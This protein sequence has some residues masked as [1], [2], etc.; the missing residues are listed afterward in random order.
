MTSSNA[1]DL[2][3]L[4]AR[5]EVR[6]IW[7]G[8]TVLVSAQ[9]GRVSGEELQGLYEQNTRILSRW[10]YQINGQRLRFVAASPVDSYSMLAYY[11]APGIKQ[12]IPP[13]SAEEDGLVLRCSRFVGQG[14]HEDIDLENFTQ[15]GVEFELSLV[16]AADFADLTAVS[17]GGRQQRALAAA[18]WSPSV[19]GGW[20]LCLRSAELGLDRAVL[21][22]APAAQPQP[23]WRDGCIAYRIALTPRQRRHLCIRVTPVFD[24][25]A[26]R[27]VYGCGAFRSRAT[28]RDR[29]REGFLSDAPRVRTANAGVQATW[30]RAVA[31]LASLARY[32]GGWPEAMVP[33]AGI[34]AYMALFGRDIL[35]AAYQAGML[36]APLMQA[37]LSVSAGSQAEHWDDFYDA[38]P[39]RII[40]QINRGPLATLGS[41]PY[42]HYY[43]DY[44]SPPAFLIV[45]GQYYSWTGDTE[46]VRRFAGVAQRV[47]NWLDGPADLDGDGFVEY[48]TRSP[49]GQKN[50]GWKDSGV[51]MVDADGRG[52]ENPIASCELQG[53][54][55]AAKQQYALALAFGLHRFGEARRLLREA[56]ELKQRFNRAYWLPKE[57]F[58]ASALGPDKR[59][60]STIGSNA[61]HALA[62]G[63]IDERYVP[64]V[65]KRLFAPDMFSGWGIRTLSS[66]HPAYNP[67]SYQ[68]GSVWPMESATIAFGLKRYGF[69][70]EVLA[71]AH[72]TFDLAGLVSHRQLPEVVGGFPRDELHPHPGLYPQAEQPQAWSAAAIP[73]FVQTLL[74]LFPFAP[75]R[76][77]LIDPVLPEWLPD[78]TL[79][80]LRIGG[81]RVSLRF[82]RER[83]GT[84]GWKLLSKQGSLRVIQ[85]PPGDALQASVWQRGAELL[86]SFIPW[87]H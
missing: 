73:Q 42:R 22:E 8:Q 48:V 39:G 38:Q 33:S 69:H 32:E 52:I 10:E 59:P 25:K 78:L 9:D 83:D 54:T 67:L 13:L 45:L 6:S 71:L 76:L 65:A 62:T 49:Q 31:D 56:A 79:S 72:A 1:S 82:H 5:P 29:I 51:A 70:R 37:A 66:G 12:Q 24:G 18:A 81:A 47:L 50:Q 4:R 64:A 36:S 57:G 63:I 53:Y 30:E 80:G 16:L 19:S 43:G 34:P 7:Q 86:D 75:L 55:Y 26:L 11:L 21:I 28:P 3:E 61:G 15:T 46:M 85:Q 2:I 68:L 20:Q 60:S 77:L 17:A 23:V 41:N 84:T 40:Q 14:M 27:P 35:T 74:G 44:V 87:R 58:I